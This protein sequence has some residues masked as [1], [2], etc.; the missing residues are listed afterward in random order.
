M[1]R[2]L[3]MNGWINYPWTEHIT[4]SGS[5]RESAFSYEGGC[6]ATMVI[7]INWESTVPVIAEILGGA[8]LNRTTGQLDRTLPVRH[9]E[10]DWLYASRIVSVKPLK[11]DSKLRLP[12]GTISGYQYSLITIVF[13]QPKWTML[14]DARIDALYGSPRKEYRRFVERR[15]EPSG[16]VV[17]RSEGSFKW[18]QGP[19]I[20]T[21]FKGPQGQF[22]PKATE[23][24][25]WKRVPQVGLFSNG[26]TGDP[27]NVY[28]AVGKVN[29]DEF[30]GNPAG[31]LLLQP[32]RLIPLEVPTIP[33]AVGANENLGQ[34]AIFYDVELPLLRFDPPYG[35][36]VRGHNNAIGPDGLWY[37]LVDA[38]NGTRRIFEEADFESIFQMVS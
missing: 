1:A 9:P 2:Q 16:E 19:Q 17:T 8:K 34:P 4:R 14:S 3:Q 28:A 31:T 35:G 29:D 32:P 18:E 38:T 22:L 6:Q 12:A 27:T 37:P 24:L 11:W 30:L 10:F 25:V 23:V 13:T 20:G 15:P 7:R 33:A 5:I 36:S 21:V 26:G